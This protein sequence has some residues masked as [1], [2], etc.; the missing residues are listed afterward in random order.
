MDWSPVIQFEMYGQKYLCHLSNWKFETHQRI[1]TRAENK[2]KQLIPCMEIFLALHS[3]RLLFVIFYRPSTKN[4]TKHSRG[5]YQMK[6]RE[7]GIMRTKNWEAKREG[8]GF[9]QRI[10]TLSHR[11]HPLKPRLT[12]ITHDLFFHRP[13]SSRGCHQ[14]LAPHL[15]PL[16]CGWPSRQPML[17]PR[18]GWYPC[19]PRHRLTVR[20][21]GRSVASCNCSKGGGRVSGVT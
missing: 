16:S 13:I 6:N 8:E 5:I 14:P 15:P 17:L 19:Q 18:Q 1:I 7:T 21:D 10:F 3:A 20:D 12:G 4:E 11:W 2:V 9:T